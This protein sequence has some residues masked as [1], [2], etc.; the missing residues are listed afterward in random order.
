MTEFKLKTFKKSILIFKAV[1]VYGIYPIFNDPGIFATWQIQ[2][3]LIRI[4]LSA[5]VR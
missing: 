4:P 3:I 2:R 1:N 5:E